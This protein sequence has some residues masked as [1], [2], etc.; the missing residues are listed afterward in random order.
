[1]LARDAVNNGLASTSYELFSFY[2]VYKVGDI[3]VIFSS[4]CI[5]VLYVV[6]VWASAF[7]TLLTSLS[8]DSSPCFHILWT[9]LPFFVPIPPLFSS[10]P[11]S[12]SSFIYRVLYI[13]HIYI[14]YMTRFYIWEKYL[15]SDLF[16]YEWCPIPSISLQMSKS[17]SSV[18]KN[19]CVYIHHGYVHI[20]FIHSLTAGHQAGSISWLMYQISLLCADTKSFLCIPEFI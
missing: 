1:M 14:Y 2:L 8:T 7:L 5:I 15:L 12:H 9:Q 6:W 4:I 10:L 20:V 11:P 13:K 16:L 3:V 19:K 18:K 17:D